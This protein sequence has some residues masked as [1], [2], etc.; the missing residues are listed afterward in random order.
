MNND[1]VTTTVKSSENLN[2]NQ[3]GEKQT[4]MVFIIDELDRCKPSFSLSILENIKHFF[5]VENICFVLVTN[6]TQ[7]HSAVK[8][9]YGD[10]DARNYLEKFYHIR[11]QFPTGDITR[12]DLRIITFCK[13]LGCSEEVSEL[14]Y[15]YDTINH[16]SLRTVERIMIYFKIIQISI[17]QNQFNLYLFS[18]TLCILK[19]MHPHEYNLAR[20]SRLR[21]PEFSKC[22]GLAHWKERHSPETLSRLSERLTELWSYALGETNDDGR[23]GQFGSGLLEYNL[24]R[25]ALVPYFCKLID[26]LKFAT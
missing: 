16:L 14:L 2:E 8:F 26:G 10:I 18:I 5:S 6:L 19:V 24:H 9:A 23:N 20:E 12:Q 3:K 13:F 21:F 17:K 1:A 11:M 4:S 22:M 15:T 7:L 25:E